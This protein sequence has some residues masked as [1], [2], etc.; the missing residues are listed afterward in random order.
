MSKYGIH[1]RFIVRNGSE[2]KL[3][4]THVFGIGKVIIP[5]SQSFK[6]LGQ[7]VH[8]NRRS[9][10]GHSIDRTTQISLQNLW[11]VSLLLEYS[12]LQ[13]ARDLMLSGHPGYETLN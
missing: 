7:C 1:Q 5:E 12:A 3:T 9:Y 6:I 2:S 4:V 8:E 10:M 11:T 13:F